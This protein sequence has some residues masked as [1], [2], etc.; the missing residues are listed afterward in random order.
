MKAGGGHAK[1]ALWERQICRRLS[2]MITSGERDDCLWRTAMSGGRATFQLRQDILN[3]A[4]AG[5]INAISVEGMALCEAYVFEAKHR[6]NLNFTAFVTGRGGL[7][8]DF[9]V[10]T[11]KVAERIGKKPV[12]IAKQDRY[13]AIVMCPISCGLFIHDPWMIFPCLDAELYDF[14]TVTAVVRPT[15]KRPKGSN[16]ETGTQAGDDRRPV[17]HLG[18]RR[19]SAA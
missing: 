11:R 10:S 1:G 13:P 19:G 4:Q 14:E 8:T 12:L 18:N 16:H 9:W 15:I 3:R 17:V 7:L 5:D 6:A 2:L